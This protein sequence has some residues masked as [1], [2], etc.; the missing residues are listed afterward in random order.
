MGSNTTKHVISEN[1]NTD[2]III[3]TFCGN[4][5]V[6]YMNCDKYD[7]ELQNGKRHGRGIMMYK[8]KDIYSGMWEDGE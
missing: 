7:G 4:H 1:I 6:K 8:N 5:T 2:D 3:D